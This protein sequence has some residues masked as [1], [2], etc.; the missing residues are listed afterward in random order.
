MGWASADQFQS[1]HVSVALRFGLVTMGSDQSVTVPPVL[2][3]LPSTAA[4]GAK[5]IDFRKRPF[6]S[7]QVPG[8]A[9]SGVAC[10]S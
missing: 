9:R 10:L 3:L 7:M 1:S 4:L 2:P 5:G 6:L 8:L